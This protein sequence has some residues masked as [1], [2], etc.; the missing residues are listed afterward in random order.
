M[1]RR[2]RRRSP[3]PS[4][5]RLKMYRMLEDVRWNQD[6]CRNLGV[7]QAET[8]WL[9]LTDMDHVVPADTF[10][11]IL[12]ASLDS[13]TAYRFARVSMPKL[14]PY[15]MHPNSWLMTKAV[16]DRGRRLRRTVSRLVWHR[17]RLQVAPRPSRPDRA[18]EGKF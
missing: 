11:K 15:K 3:P 13:D 4:A 18:A 16:F 1:D 5:C 8:D 6:A 17:R 9:L 14:D 7:S 2:T 12:K 10:E